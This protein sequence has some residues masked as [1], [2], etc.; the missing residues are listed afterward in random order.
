MLIFLWN[1]ASEIAQDR[2][3]IAPHLQGSSIAA[4]ALQ[5]IDRP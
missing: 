2:G 3:T 1:R 4:T 5:T